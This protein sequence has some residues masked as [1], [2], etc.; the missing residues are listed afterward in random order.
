V[1]V[2]G[3]GTATLE[4]NAVGLEPG[5]DIV[6][7]GTI[8]PAGGIQHN[9][10]VVQLQGDVSENTSGGAGGGSTSGGSTSGG[11]GGPGSVGPSPQELPTLSGLTAAKT[12][13]HEGRS[14]P[15]LN[16]TGH[17]SG[18]VVSVSL[19]EAAKVTLE[20]LKPAP[21][22]FANGHCS[23]PSK[24][25][26]GA[27]HCTRRIAAGSVSFQANAGPNTVAFSG[28]LSPSKKLKPGA[29][30][31]AVTASDAGGTS[32]VSKLAITILP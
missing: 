14:L 11:G 24:S 29:Y 3:V 4:G 8:K 9:L 10:V 30:T 6:V 18:L 7:G 12:H 26:K 28:R 31:L 19:S 27:R 2:I 23:A 15:K 5:G 16:P 13:F 17:P 20:F 21:G 32:T 22:R 1:S 25:N